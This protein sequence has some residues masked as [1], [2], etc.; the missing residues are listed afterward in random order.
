MNK[1]KSNNNRTK[2][3]IKIIK[4]I[5]NKSYNKIDNKSKN[6]NTDNGSYYNKNYL[7]K[8]LQKISIVDYNKH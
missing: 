2:N 4:N 5:H 8:R 3:N 7:D 6:N 1:K